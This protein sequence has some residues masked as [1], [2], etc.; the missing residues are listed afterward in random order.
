M[1]TQKEL[2]EEYAEIYNM[3]RKPQTK[4]SAKDFDYVVKLSDGSMIAL[5]KPRIEKSFCYADHLDDAFDNVQKIR[6][7][8]EFFISEN[9]RESCD[10]VMGYYNNPYHNYWVQNL[11]SPLNNESK[12]KQI[13]HGYRVEMENARRLNSEDIEQILSV[14]Q[15]IRVEFEKRLRAY[16][17]RYGLKSVRAWTYWADA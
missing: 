14:Y 12:I 13:V 7:D 3:E 5:N 8:P 9:L 6:T 10:R 15:I 4:R 1:K 16:V 17:K 11:Y 2:R